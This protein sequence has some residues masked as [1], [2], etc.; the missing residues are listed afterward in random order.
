MLVQAA[1]IAVRA[2]IGRQVSVMRRR[3]VHSFS[4]A[5]RRDVRSWLFS[6]VA[7][8]VCA[9]RRCITS[10]VGCGIK[11]RRLPIFGNRPRLPPYSESVGRG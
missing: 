2:D 8:G 7:T 3:T 4:G 1:R 9:N 10:L 5:T 11:T 6:P